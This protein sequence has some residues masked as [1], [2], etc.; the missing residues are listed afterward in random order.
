MIALIA[1]LVLLF[2]GVARSA[3]LPITTTTAATL[4]FS[5]PTATFV[6]DPG[7]SGTVLTATSA[8]ANPSITIAGASVEIGQNGA[9]PGVPAYGQL[10]FDSLTSISL[11]GDF[12]FDLQ[13][14]ATPGVDFDQIVVLRGDIDLSNTTLTLNP[15]FAPAPGDSFN[16]LSLQGTSTRTGTFANAAEGATLNIGGTD[17]TITYLGGAGSD[18]VLT[19][20]AAA[21]PSV[22]LT[23]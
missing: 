22:D 21:P 17:Y 15:T 1:S 23:E 7:V 6:T 3:T 12:V 11:S 16:L 2:A 10:V 20:G 4:V 9:V 8:V 18:I 19:A 13:G 14:T 5:F